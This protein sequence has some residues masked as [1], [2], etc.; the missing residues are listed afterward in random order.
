MVSWTT[1]SYLKFWLIRNSERKVSISSIHANVV[2]IVG[3]WTL[4]VALVPLPYEMFWLSFCFLRLCVHSVFIS[5]ALFFF[6]GD[7]YFYFLKIISK[8]WNAFFPRTKWQNKSILETSDFKRIFTTCANWTFS[9][10]LKTGPCL[11]GRTGGHVP[12]RPP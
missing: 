12:L 7:K 6:E 8:E 3:F 5:L 10:C 11:A 2:E 1:Y 4:P 9:K